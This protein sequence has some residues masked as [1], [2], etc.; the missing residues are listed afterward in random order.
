MI[1]RDSNI[2]RLLKTCSSE[3]ADRVPNFEFFVMGR[4]MKYFLG[5]KRINK[6]M[7][8][9][10]MK[11]LL[12]LLS[13]EE[14]EKELEKKISKNPLLRRMKSA[15]SLVSSVV[16][17]PPDEN[18]KLLRTTGVDA[19]SPM[20]DWLPR[21]REYRPEIDSYGQEGIVR[22]WEDLDKVSLPPRRVEKMMELID[23]YLDVCKGTDVGVGPLCGS[24]LYNTYEVLGMENFML[25][26]YDDI[27]L[28]EHIMDIFIDYGLKITTE[29]SKRDIDCFWLNDDLA[30]NNG[31]LV[32]PKFIKDLWVPRTRKML[33]PLR[34]KNIPIYTHCCAN[35][36]DFIP[37]AIDLGIKAIHPVQPNCNDIYALK[38]EYGDKMCFVGNMDLA[39]VLSFGTPDEV[40]KDTKEHIDKLASGGGYVVASSHSITDDVPP[41]NYIAMIETAQTYGKY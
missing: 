20:L 8:S 18:L 34:E 24:C 4:T 9:E 7:K 39:G 31:F 14:S 30:F 2:K 3:E 35:I 38:K 10:E 16:F 25:K 5:E 11:H 23:W 28:V 15:S 37:I 17:L 26:L 21:T 29:L 22:G 27:K 32:Q 13:D 33:K 41:E 19:A 12:Y 1:R 40:I 6:I 36:R